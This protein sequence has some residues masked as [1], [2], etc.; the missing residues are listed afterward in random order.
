VQH[1]FIEELHKPVIVNTK[2]DPKK[3]SAWKVIARRLV[4]DSIVGNTKLNR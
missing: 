4:T 1:L 2:R 3:M